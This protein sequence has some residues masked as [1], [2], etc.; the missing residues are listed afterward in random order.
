MTIG[1]ILVSLIIILIIVS[2][3]LGIRI[4]PENEVWIFERLGEFYKALGPGINFTVPFLDR[5]KTIV[6]EIKK[7]DSTGKI[8]DIKKFKKKA[9]VPIEKDINIDIDPI[10]MI[11]KDNA[12]ILVDTIIF[13][14]IPRTEGSTAR[15]GVYSN[16]VKAIYE[17]DDYEEGTVEATLTQLRSIIGSNTLNDIL[18]NKIILNGKEVKI[19]EEIKNLVQGYVGNWGITVKT[20]DIQKLE[21]GQKMREAMEKQAAAERERAAIEM[22]AE[23]EKTAKIK[24]AEAEKE[25]AI[26]K[27][28]GIQKAAHLE[29]DAQLALAKAS[30]ESMKLIAD[31]MKGGQELPAMY[32]LGERY[33]KA[34]GTLSESSNSKF[35]VYPAD[36]QATVRGLTG[37]AFAGSTMGT[38]MGMGMQEAMNHPQE[39]QQQ[40][41]PQ[42]SQEETNTETNKETKEEPKQNSTDDTNLPTM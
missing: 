1:L 26:R 3:Y 4:V 35:V 22:K 18:D 28:E 41:I 42:K 34:L 23:A 39:T 10:E 36:I 30:A 24:A 20:F 31:S 8:I 27:A 16:A 6:K 32:L 9:I 15:G 37:N 14:R 29:A 17:V 25:A 33:I 7:K 40:A 2:I 21:P 11:T 12:N 38:M 5:H 13:I 19:E